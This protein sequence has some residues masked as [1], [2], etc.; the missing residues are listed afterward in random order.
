M[1]NLCQ[2]SQ[3]FIW[4]LNGAQT[5]TFPNPVEWG[6]QL[7][8]AHQLLLMHV[9]PAGRGGLH[10]AP[11]EQNSH[12]KVQN[13]LV[14]SESPTHSTQRPLSQIVAWPRLQSELA[15][16]IGGLVGLGGNSIETILA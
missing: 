16:H 1:P 4:S 2:F 11:E 13:S 7:P 12:R 10:L 3:L 6:M 5:Q 8:D 9:A 14:Q 15:T